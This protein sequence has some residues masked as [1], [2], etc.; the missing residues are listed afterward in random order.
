MTKSEII[1]LMAGVLMLASL[2]FLEVFGFRVWFLA[3][4]FYFSGLIWMWLKE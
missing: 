3:K 2:P 1:M 4:A